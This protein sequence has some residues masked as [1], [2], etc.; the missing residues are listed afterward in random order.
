MATMERQYGQRKKGTI[1]MERNNQHKSNKIIRQL[2]KKKQPMA[3]NRRM[4]NGH[5]QREN[6]SENIHHRQRQKQ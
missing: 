6:Q 4:Q 2:R 3:N 5:R 1:G